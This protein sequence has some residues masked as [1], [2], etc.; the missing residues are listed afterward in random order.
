MLEIK[1]KNKLKTL[2][3]NKIEKEKEHKRRRMQV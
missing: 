1:Y 3:K 2:R